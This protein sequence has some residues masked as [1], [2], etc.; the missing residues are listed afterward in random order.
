MSSQ[1]ST[2]KASRSLGGCI[3]KARISFHL[4]FAIT[5]RFFFYLLMR[6]L[7]RTHGSCWSREK[8]QLVAF[9]LIAERRTKKYNPSKLY[10][11]KINKIFMVYS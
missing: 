9:S 6:R 8:Q 1:E 3:G 4:R 5:D 11:I 7:K 2:W 10:N